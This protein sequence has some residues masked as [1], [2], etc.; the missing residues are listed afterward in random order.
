MCE[1][2]SCTAVIDTIS[3]FN[4]GAASQITLLN[5]VSIESPSNK[6]SAMREQDQSCIAVAT[7][8]VS[9]KARMQRKKLRAKSLNKK[10]EMSVQYQAESFGLSS[11]PEN[12]TS[13]KKTQE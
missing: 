11:G 5:S 1:N 13:V 6:F 7:K 12:I 8:K 10:N 9:E 3:Y 2:K 4:T